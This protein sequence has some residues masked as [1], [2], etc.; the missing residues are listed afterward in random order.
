MPRKLADF[1]MTRPGTSMRGIH[2]LRGLRTISS[3]QSTVRFLPTQSES[4]DAVDASFVLAG[5]MH[6]VNFIG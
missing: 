6:A 4:E 1:S 3:L 5:A 2:R